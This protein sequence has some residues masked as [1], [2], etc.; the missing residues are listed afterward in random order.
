MVRKIKNLAT[1]NTELDKL[2]A[3]V[4]VTNDFDFGPVTLDHDNGLKP[5][6]TQAVALNDAVKK[7]TGFANK[8]AHSGAAF[9]KEQ[10]TKEFEK[11]LQNPR[12]F[13]TVKE[14]MR[15]DEHPVEHSVTTAGSSD[16]VEDRQASL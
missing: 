1:L 14:V 8:L 6:L 13:D 2:L 5:E 9:A 3:K 7:L 11:L 16:G 15:N 10:Q 12:V 4:D